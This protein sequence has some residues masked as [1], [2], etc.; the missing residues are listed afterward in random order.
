ME[1]VMCLDCGHFQPA[2]HRGSALEPIA[3]T[4]ERCGGRSFESGDG[5]ES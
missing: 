5:S 3:E 4:C 2:V 1:L